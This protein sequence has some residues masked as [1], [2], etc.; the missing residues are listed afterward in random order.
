[1]LHLCSIY[2]W[3]NTFLWINTIFFLNHSHKYF[4]KQYS[5]NKFITKCSLSICSQLPECQIFLKIIN[6]GQEI[7]F[8]VAEDFKIWYISL[9]VIFHACKEIHIFLNI[10]LNSEENVFYV[11]SFSSN[12]GLE[13]LGLYNILSQSS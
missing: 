2:F 13:I 10:I 3:Y 6:I 4:I 12:L 5:K 9:L 11:S 1:M 8:N 7:S